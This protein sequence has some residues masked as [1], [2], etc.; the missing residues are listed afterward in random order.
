MDSAFVSL[1]ALGGSDFEKQKAGALAPAFLL[2]QR[3]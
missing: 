2:Q 3:E 1:C